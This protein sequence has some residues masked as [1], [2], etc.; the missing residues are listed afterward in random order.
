MFFSCEI[1]T[2]KMRGMKRKTEIQQHFKANAHIP[3]QGEHICTYMY[4]DNTYT[5]T[6]T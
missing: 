6:I 5:Y 2:Q 3:L 4:V 1:L